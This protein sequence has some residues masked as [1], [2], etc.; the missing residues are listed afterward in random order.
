[1]SGQHVLD[2]MLGNSGGNMC[3][4]AGCVGRT[5]TMMVIK[6]KRRIRR[7]V[8]A[9][10]VGCWD[11]RICGPQSWNGC[12]DLRI[13]SQKS[14]ETGKEFSEPRGGGGKV[15][16]VGNGRGRRICKLQF[17][18][19]TAQKGNGNGRCRK[20]ID[21]LQKKVDVLQR[22]CFAEPARRGE[23]A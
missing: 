12:W 19:D 6:K 20:K 14:L 4:Q 15:F 11:L 22:Q 8:L 21:I 13:W 16:I 9:R 17:L 1:M 23:S 18:H 2:K 5:T 10:C 7:N 3:R